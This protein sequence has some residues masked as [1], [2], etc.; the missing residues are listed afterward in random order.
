MA[1]INLLNNDPKFFYYS[2]QG[3]FTQKSIPFGDDRQGGGSSNQPFIQFPLPENAS[4]NVRQYYEF[5][6]IGIDYPLRG[7]RGINLS[8]TGPNIPEAA[9]IDRLRIEQFFKTTKGNIFLIKQKNLQFANPKM[10]VG[11]A[12]VPFN[13]QV[14]T[15]FRGGIEYTRV[16]NDGKNTSAQVGVQGS[17]FHYDRHGLR[18]VNPF[19]LSYEYVVKNKDKEL[20]RLLFLY[21]TKLENNRTINFGTFSTLGVSTS[22]DLLLEYLGGPDSAGGLGFTTI[23]RTSYTDQSDIDINKGDIN[24]NIFTLNY[25]QLSSRL[26]QQQKGNP[27]IRNDF[28]RQFLGQIAATN[29]NQY[30]L[31][32]KYGIGDP[33]DKN[34]IRTDYREN[35]IQGVDL[36]NDSRPRITDPGTNPWGEKDVAGNDLIKF[37]F[38]AINYTDPSTSIFV[39]FRAFLNSF[40]DNHQANYNSVK[41]IGRGETFYA[42]DGFTREISFGFI[43]AAQTRQELLPL[44]DKLNILASQIYPDYG[45]NSFMKTPVVKMTIGDY[46]YRQPGFLNSINLSIESDYPWEIKLNKTEEIAQLPQVIKADCQFTPLHNFLPKRT[47]TISSVNGIIP[48]ITGLINSERYKIDPSVRSDLPIFNTS[49]LNPQLNTTGVV[50]PNTS[51]APRI[52]DTGQQNRFGIVA[53]NPSLRF[54]NTIRG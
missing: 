10:E 39:Q 45:A 6:R 2:G 30:N 35:N 24:Q 21:R 13:Q 51:G 18:P 27:Q 43:I 1:L 19:Q 37:G 41:Y 8:L 25:N 42:Y 52:G 54:G 9:R 48:N 15:L 49:P 3:N 26:P 36:V 14:G 46:I 17:G 34:I 33:G 53:P 11:E 44:Y 29:Y 22:N 5:N 38:E 31:S 50:L 20:N 28:R 7:G 16:Y 4:D 47:D 23:R 12:A 32:Y 40:S